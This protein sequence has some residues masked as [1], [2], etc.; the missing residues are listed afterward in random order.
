M[1]K[2]LRLT[3]QLKKD[4]IMEIVEKIVKQHYYPT[5]DCLA[6]CQEFKQT[7]ACA[8]L[9]KKL[10]NYYE[11]VQQYLLVMKEMDKKDIKFELKLARDHNWNVRFPIT[12]ENMMP[13]TSKMDQLIKR[14][15]K[16]CKKNYND[17]DIGKEQEIW[18]S[19]L[20]V[21]YELRE[22][23]QMNKYSFCRDYFRKRI[24]EFTSQLV[25][26]IPF[27]SFLEWLT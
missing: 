16:T 5:E 26:C 3:C 21:L 15:T 9:N 11:S 10:K 14:V 1:K 6:I 23:E 25:T 12:T 18:Y 4:N 22:D 24:D 13:R 2:H 7:E 27:K 20:Q 17:V 19:V 8:L